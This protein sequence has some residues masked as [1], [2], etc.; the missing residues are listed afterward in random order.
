MLLSS[1]GSCGLPLQQGKA[2]A[3]VLMSY[4]EFLFNSFI[5]YKDIFYVQN[6][7]AV[8]YLIFLFFP[9]FVH[10]MYCIF[11]ACD[12]FCMFFSCLSK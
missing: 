12:I 2:S 10:C 5:F 6:L 8:I 4:P 1:P 3:S 9:K 7:H 11:I